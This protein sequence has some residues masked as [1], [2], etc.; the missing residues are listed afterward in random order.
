MQN[1]ETK[2]LHSTEIM[3]V[4]DG[5]DVLI[6]EYGTLQTKNLGEFTA[7]LSNNI[8]SVI[9]TPTAVNGMPAGNPGGYWSGIEDT[10]SNTLRVSGDFLT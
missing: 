1:Q 3:I 8:I 9:Y 2:Y 10:I 5:V 6:S 4:H 7:T